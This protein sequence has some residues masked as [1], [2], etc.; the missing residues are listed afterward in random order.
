LREEH[1]EG[2]RRQG[3]VEDIGTQDR[4][5]NRGWVNCIMTYSM[6]LSPSIEAT[7]SLASQEISSIL[8]NQKV[9]YH[10]RKHPHMSLSLAGSIQCMLPHPYFLKIPCNIIFIYKPDLPSQVFRPKFYN[11]KL[12]YFY[13]LSDIFGPGQ[14]RWDGWDIYHARETLEMRLDFYL[15]NIETSDHL[16]KMGQVGGSY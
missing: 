11:E 3:A 1:A 16:E 7:R 9:H 8:W 4:G 10:V 2:I 12:N 6:E 5:S 13:F 14:R 15:D